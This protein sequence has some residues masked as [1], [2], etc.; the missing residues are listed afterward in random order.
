MPLRLTAKA[1]PESLA[2]P[3]LSQTAYDTLPS[4]GVESLAEIDK[5]CRIRTQKV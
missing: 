3:R 1:Y 5:L 4:L 2:H